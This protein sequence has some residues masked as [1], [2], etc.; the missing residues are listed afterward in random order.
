MTVNT[1]EKFLSSSRGRMAWL[2]LL[3][4]QILP[5]NVH[6]YRV[7]DAIDMQIR[8]AKDKPGEHL[9]P[10]HHQLPVS[11]KNE[12]YCTSWLHPPENAGGAKS[13]EVA[14]VDVPIL[15]LC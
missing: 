4:L 12:F 2:F 8:T 10:K 3:L 13:A 6:A 11:L 7:G 1:T 14:E 15:R 5:R 9:A